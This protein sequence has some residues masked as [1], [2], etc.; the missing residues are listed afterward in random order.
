[1]DLLEHHNAC[2]CQSRPGRFWIRRAQVATAWVG[3]AFDAVA[4]WPQLAGAALLT[5]G[6]CRSKFV[7]CE[8]D[9][10]HTCNMAV[11]TCACCTSHAAVQPHS[12]RA[13]C[14]C[15]GY[16][17][18]YQLLLADDDAEVEHRAQLMMSAA[19]V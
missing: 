15:S 19:S 4:Q 16:A 18:R 17:G 12:M 3:E 10:Q 13:E 14:A 9:L 6:Q 7:V 2:F 5:L 8:D 11:T 1:M